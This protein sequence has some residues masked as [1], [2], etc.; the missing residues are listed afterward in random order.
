MLDTDCVTM[1]HT[2]PPCPWT[3]GAPKPVRPGAAARPHADERVRRDPMRLQCFEQYGRRR[4][5]HL[6]VTRR[7]AGE[8]YKELGHRGT[9]TK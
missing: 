5:W 2:T 4:R 7:R 3:R 6:L 8:H 1:R 9:W